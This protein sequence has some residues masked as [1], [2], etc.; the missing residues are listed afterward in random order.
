V[1]A[2]LKKD[3]DEMFNEIAAEMA[4]RDPH[5]QKMWTF[6][7]D[8]ERALQQRAL[9]V[10]QPLRATFYLIL[11]LFHVLEYLWK[12]AYAFH[13]EGSPQAE[14]WVTGTPAGPLARTGEPRRRW[15]AAECHQA[16][17]ARAETPGRG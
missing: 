8:G 5:R 6:L 16:Q 12:A 14:Q 4:K 9:A 17:A 3:K 2:S 10:L 7:C 1:W 15:L 11:D 13:P